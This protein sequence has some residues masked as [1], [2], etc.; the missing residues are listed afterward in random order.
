MPERKIGL[1]TFYNSVFGKRGFQLAPHHYPMVAA[2]E[3]SRINNVLFMLCAGAGKSVLLDIIYPSWELG[4][5]P[6]LSIL[7]VSAGEKLPQ[8]FMLAT[9]Q[10]IADDPA[11][12]Q[13]FPDVFPDKGA[14]WSLDRGLFV[15]GHHPGDENPSYFCAGLASKAL[16]GIH[17]RVEIFDDLHDEENARTPEGR[18]EVLDR[19]YRTLLDRADPRGCRRVAVGRW[20]AG[21]DIYQEWRK[22]G[23][24]V[25]MEL[26]ATR[27]GGSKRLWYDVYVPKGMECVFTE[28][29]EPEPEQDPTSLYVHYKAYYAAIDQTGAGFYWP[30]SPTKRRNYEVVKRRRPRVAA[31]NYDGDMTGGGTGLLAEEDF[32]PYVPPPG[33]DMGIQAPDV[34]RWIAEFQGAEIE[35]AWDTALGQPQ[36]KSL[37]VALTGLLVPCSEWHC[38][39]DPD[40]VGPCDFHWD[41]WLLDLMARNINFKE[42]AM[43]LRSRH[44]KWHPRRVTVEEKQS[45]V[46][47]LQVFRGTH[48]PVVGQK[49]EQGKVERATNPVL[50]QD[51]G[52]PIPGGGASMEGWVKLHR[53]RVPGGAAWLTGPHGDAAEGFLKRVC[54]F[55]GGTKATDEFD[56]LV[57]LVTRAISRGRQVAYVPGFGQAATPLPVP[58]P[59]GMEDPRTAA[60]DAFQGIAQTA[61]QPDLVVSPYVGMCGA[62]CHYYGVWDNAERCRKHRRVTSAMNGCPDW[63]KHGSVVEDPA[64]AGL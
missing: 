38:G 34:R 49:V 32:I 18:A 3:D 12:R 28:T 52:L 61:I 9:M 21:D 51:D 33:L 43:A 17:C 22:S 1:A 62:P 56:A 30:G 42:L 54:S 10:V 39:E 7:S 27:K 16:T 64:L 5:D 59:F 44:G 6:S 53:V 48:I 4:H 58:L 63:A 60:M 41:V 24:W 20:W 15:T 14:G 11:F 50:K 35:E 19:Y 47:L 37:T 8:T 25:V 45:G 36:S 40:L 46:G 57:H 29:L 55:A 2:L 23:D 31:I 26:P 13:T